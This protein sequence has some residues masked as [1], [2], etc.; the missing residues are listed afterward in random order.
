MK[1]ADR[2][3]E[4]VGKKGE[5]HALDDKVEFVITKNGKDILQEVHEDF[6]L[7]KWA[8]SSNDKVTP[9]YYCPLT[10]FYLKQRLD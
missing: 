2:L 9:D 10:N 1:Y 3:N 6:V 7:I 8:Y 5:L 4:F